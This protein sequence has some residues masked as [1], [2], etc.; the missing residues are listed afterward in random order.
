[1]SPGIPA[2]QGPAQDC[3]VDKIDEFRS[4][5]AAPSTARAERRLAL[6]FLLHFIGDLHQPLHAGDRHDRGGNDERVQAAGAPAG[7][8]HHYWDTVFVERLGPDPKAVADR[9]I[10][11]IDTD[12]RRRW[13]AGSTNDWARE[14]YQLAQLDVY[15]RLPPPGTDGLYRLADD[16]SDAAVAIVRTQL[17]RAGVRLALVL[18]Q[19]FTTAAAAPA[20][21]TGAAATAAPVR[22]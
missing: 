22:P 16:Y 5:L 10:A 8:L 4:E 14:S 2:S 20:D 11:D 12:K 7:T 19:A 6:Q 18:N 17:E 1:M 15:G 21:R 13:S 3:I 9:L